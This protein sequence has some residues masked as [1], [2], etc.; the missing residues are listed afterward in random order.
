MTETSSAA[1]RSVSVYGWSVQN[2]HSLKLTLRTCKRTC[3]YAFSKGKKSCSNHSILKGYVN[4]RDGI[5][6]YDYMFF[7]ATETSQRLK[8]IQTLKYFRGKAWMGGM[9]LTWMSRWKLG[10]MVSKWVKTSIYPIYK[11]AIHPQN[12]TCNPKMKVWKMFFHSSFLGCKPF[13]NL[14]S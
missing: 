1:F 13:T 12:L 7:V 10:S 2:L 14:W 5:R 4:S 11:K 8:I 6:D 3:K 9:S